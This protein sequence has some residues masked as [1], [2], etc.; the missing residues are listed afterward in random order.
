MP[1]S[2]VVLLNM[3]ENDDSKLQT[4]FGVHITSNIFKIIPILKSWDGTNPPNLPTLKAYPTSG[5]GGRFKIFFAKM[6][7]KKWT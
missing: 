4:K 2:W 3:L 7:E 5:E 6:T 1:F